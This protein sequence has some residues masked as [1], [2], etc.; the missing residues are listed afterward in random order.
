ML[1]LQ[2]KVRKSQY[3]HLLDRDYL[4]QSARQSILNE[5][6]RETQVAPVLHSMRESLGFSKN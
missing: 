3:S 5:G 1:D 2:K 6:N 4:L